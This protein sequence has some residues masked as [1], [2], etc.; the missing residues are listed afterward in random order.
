MP[1][2]GAGVPVAGVAAEKLRVVPQGIDAADFDPNKHQP[3]SLRSLPSA[4][5]VT[6]SDNG[7][8]TALEKPYG[9]LFVVPVFSL[10]RHCLRTLCWICMDSQMSMPQSQFDHACAP[11][12][13]LATLTLDKQCGATEAGPMTSACWHAC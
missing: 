11:G 12:L 8:T 3:L 4:Q 13:L 2:H 5:L 6:G 9:V 7:N 1:C 10:A